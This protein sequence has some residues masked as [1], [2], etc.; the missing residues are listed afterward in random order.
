M[1]EQL[2][3]IV[4]LQNLDTIII[5]IKKNIEMIPLKI[6][7]DQHELKAAQESY[8]LSQSNLITLEKKKKEKEGDIRELGAKMTKLREKTS[9]IKTNKEYQAY[10][11]EVENMKK[12]LDKAEEELLN[13]MESLDESKKIIELKKAKVKEEEEKLEVIKRKINLEKNKGERELKNLM[14]TRKEFVNKI[15]KDHYDIY[16]NLLKVCKGQAVVEVRDEI[17]YGC[18]LHI[19][20][21]QYVKIKNNNEFSSC[22]QCRRI[23][24]YK[25][26][27][28]AP[29][30]AN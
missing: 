17:C 2:K 21:Q 11:K 5:S 7:N 3:L 22:P 8:E 16:M 20:P 1:N 15:E 18:N 29:V 10:I 28:E 4:E 24:Y 30:P 13:I 25:K 14:N 26:P 23:L 6:T 27:E 12:E 9:G 19:P